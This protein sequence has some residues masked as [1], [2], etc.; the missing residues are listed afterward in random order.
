MAAIDGIA[1]VQKHHLKEPSSGG[2]GRPGGGKGGVK[3]IPSES[4][5]GW[6]PSWPGREGKGIRRTGPKGVKGS[7]GKGDEGECR[8]KGSMQHAVPDDFAANK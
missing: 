5:A 6:L 7:Y 1:P 3:G 8:G 4:Y 2:D